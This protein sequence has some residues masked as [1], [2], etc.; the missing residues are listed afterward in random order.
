M[1]RKEE[2]E[3]IIINARNELNDITDKE[4]EIEDAKFVGRFFKTENN[5]SCPEKPSDYWWLYIK[6]ITNSEGIHT[7]RFQA[8]KDGKIEIDPLHYYLRPSLES[9]VEITEKEYSNAWEKLKKKISN[10]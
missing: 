4:D 8:D 9:Y 7:F 1:D 6:V 5:Y 2:L 3:D 10:Y